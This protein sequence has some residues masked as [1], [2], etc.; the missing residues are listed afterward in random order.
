[1]KIAPLQCVEEDDLQGIAPN[2]ELPHFNP[3]PPLYA[4]RFCPVPGH[5]NILGLA[6][7]DGNI[8]FQNIDKVTTDLEKEYLQE[9]W[10]IESS[11]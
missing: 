2:L 4:L 3:E 5:E 1:M 11:E 7:E 6:N 10:N 8:A 9:C